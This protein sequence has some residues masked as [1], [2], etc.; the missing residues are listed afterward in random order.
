MNLNRPPKSIPRPVPPL[1]RISLMIPYVMEEASRLDRGLTLNEI[2]DLVLSR[3]TSVSQQMLRYF[4]AVDAAA[5][6]TALPLIMRKLT[7]TYTNIEVQVFHLFSFLSLLLL[8]TYDTSYLT[9]LTSA[10]PLPNGHAAVLCTSISRFPF[11]I[12]YFPLPFPLLTCPNDSQ[13]VQM[14]DLPLGMRSS[15]SRDVLL[16]IYFHLRTAVKRW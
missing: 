15:P 13:S 16:A 2:H 6:T 11:M 5:S 1:A 9:D 7:M 8:T 4:S 12:I 14:P 3:Q 10:R